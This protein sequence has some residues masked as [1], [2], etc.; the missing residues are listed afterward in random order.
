VIRREALYPQVPSD[1]ENPPLNL[2]R[3]FNFENKRQNAPQESD[4]ENPP[5]AKP[6]EF[7]QHDPNNVRKGN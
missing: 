7:Q 4:S 5:K 1:L 3:V 2:T 6:K